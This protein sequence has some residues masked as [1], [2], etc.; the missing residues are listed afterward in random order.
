MLVVCGACAGCQVCAPCYVG[1]PSPY[2]KQWCQG[3]AS[4][5]KSHKCPQCK[6]L[7]LYSRAHATTKRCEFDEYSR[8]WCAYVC[9][10]HVVDGART[11]AYYMSSMVCVRVLTTSTCDMFSSDGTSYMCCGSS[12]SGFHSNT[13]VFLSSFLP[14]QCK[15]RIKTGLADVGK[16]SSAGVGRTHHR[17]VLSLRAT[18]WCALR[19]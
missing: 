15:F 2:K 10:L 13:L 18:W 16:M 1:A 5:S 17:H 14:R 3:V 8:R 12:G 7:G 6:R 19:S 4:W 9:L 11:C